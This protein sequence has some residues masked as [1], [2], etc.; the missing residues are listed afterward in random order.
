MSETSTFRDGVSVKIDLFRITEKGLQAIEGINS[1]AVRVRERW[2]GG[3]K[4][5]RSADGGKPTYGD[6]QAGI[7]SAAQSARNIEAALGKAME[8]TLG[9]HAKVDRLI[10]ASAENSVR[11]SPEGANSRA[12]DK[13]PRNGALPHQ[14][15]AAEALR[16]LLESKKAVLAGEIEESYGR[17]CAERGLAPKNHQTF[18]LLLKRMA[19]QGLVSLKLTGCKELGIKGHGSRLVVALTEKGEG[20]LRENAEAIAL[21][22]SK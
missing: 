5:E 7:S 6:A 20:F 21:K 14:A 18:G 19:S 17:L 2:H 11:G 1:G 16:E 22:R 8:M 3:A 13:N 4:T 15:L 10:A 12:G 9:L